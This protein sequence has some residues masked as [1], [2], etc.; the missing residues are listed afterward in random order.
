V[1]LVGGLQWANMRGADAEGT[2]GLLGGKAGVRVQ[3][4]FS[5]HWALQTGG[6]YQMQGAQKDTMLTLSLGPT[7]TG[8]LEWTKRTRLQYLAFPI[9]L[10]GEIYAPWHVF[11]GP[12]FGIFLNGTGELEQRVSIGDS[13]KHTTQ[14]RTIPRDEVAPVDITVVTGLMYHKA[15]WQVELGYA[16]GM[17]DIP[18]VGEE[19]DMQH[20]TFFFQMGYFFAINRR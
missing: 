19:R 2:T 9:I 20:S 6:M 17:T 8:R 5:A 15:P 16:L 13:T 12:S 14:S 10:H 3:W 11:V 1:G 4:N 18:R 7:S